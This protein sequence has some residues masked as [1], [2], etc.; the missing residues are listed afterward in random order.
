MCPRR[1]VLTHLLTAP[2][3]LSSLFACCRDYRRIFVITNDDSPDCDVEAA[4]MR[5][6]VGRML[7][8]LSRNAV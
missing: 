4:R 3:F 2:S 1:T 7:F 8:S 6:L 5:A